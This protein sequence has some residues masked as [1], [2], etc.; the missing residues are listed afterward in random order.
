MSGMARLFSAYI[1][2]I[3]KAYGLS[4]KEAYIFAGKRTK[5]YVDGCIIRNPDALDVLKDMERAAK[6]VAID[7]EGRLRG[8]V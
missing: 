3:M 8:H 2:A 6:E 4:K 1:E 5:G 7:F